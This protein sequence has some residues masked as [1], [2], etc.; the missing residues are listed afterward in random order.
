VP[1]AGAPAPVHAALGGTQ[2]RP[3]GQRASGAV[4]PRSRCRAARQV[5]GQQAAETRRCQVAEE[6][7][8]PPGGRTQ[9][10]GARRCPFYEVSGSHGAF[11][12]A[13]R[14]SKFYFNR[15][16]TEPTTAEEFCLT[17]GR[18]S[19]GSQQ[20]LSLVDASLNKLA[21]R[22]ARWLLLSPCSAHEVLP[23]PISGR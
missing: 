6:M 21:Q 14:G 11:T 16:P 10:A 1:R 18:R 17:T 15:N 8:G 12:S 13:F 3:G 19:R 5:P 2:A 4:V 7:R 20:W 22:T 9:E 23:L